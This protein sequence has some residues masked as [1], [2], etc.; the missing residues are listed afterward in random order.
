VPGA[1]SPSVH[2]PRWTVAIVGR[3]LAAV[4][5]TTRSRNDIEVGLE[6]ALR[7]SAIPG[8]VSAYL[9]GS[10]A[11]GRAHRES[12]I[13]VGVLVRHDAH[14]T[15]RARF[16]VRVRLASEL[17]KAVAGVAVDV[18]V[19]NDAPPL[20]AR[21]IVTRGRRIL[22]EDPEHDHAFIRDVQ[23]RAADVEPFLRR[24]RRLKLQALARA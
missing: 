12:D 16:E 1:I 6:A 19:L 21:H 7:A 3:I 17:P 8:L 5:V 2:T 15:A 13:D 22:L 14:P 9:F 23:L 20:L 4:S 24:T 18:V 11:S 10:H